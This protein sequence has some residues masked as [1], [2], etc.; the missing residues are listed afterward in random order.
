[1]PES[2]NPLGPWRPALLP[3]AN[4]A[5]PCATTTT[6]FIICIVLQNHQDKTLK[7]NVLSSCIVW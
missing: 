6:H 3:A 7:T 4:S 1:M 5:A 2:G